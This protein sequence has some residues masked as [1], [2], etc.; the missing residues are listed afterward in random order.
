AY[1][2]TPDD[3]GLY[4]ESVH[5]LMKKVAGVPL[6]RPEWYFDINRQGEGLNDVGT[7]LVDLVPWM[8]FPEQALDYQSDIQMISAKRW[9]T[10]LSKSDFQKVTGETDYPEHLLQYLKGED[11][12]YFCNTSVTYSV[13]G[14]HA[15]LDVLWNFEAKSGEGDTHLA[16]LKGTKSSVEIH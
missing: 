2:G 8:Y 15:K 13:R 1:P 5:Y 10:N 14:I 4:V 11:L 9:P 7:H 6:R 12:P 16:I 3:P